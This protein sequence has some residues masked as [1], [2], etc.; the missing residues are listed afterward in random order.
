MRAEYNK[1]FD[2]ITSDLSDDELLYAALRKAEAMETNKKSIKKPVIAACAAAAVVALGV[3]GAAAAGVLRFDEL[4]GKQITASSEELAADLMG[5]AQVLNATCS[6]DDYVVQL[7]GVTGTANSIIANIGAARSDG[8]PLSGDAE[9]GRVAAK[10]EDVDKNLTASYRS[11]V[12]ENGAASFTIE[13]SMSP[14]DF[15]SDE[16]LTGK[17]ILMELTGI[18]LDGAKPFEFSVEYVYTPSEASLGSLSGEDLT[19]SCN[20]LFNISGEGE[21]PTGRDIPFEV[22]LDSI[23]LRAEKGVISGSYDLGGYDFDKYV[24]NTFMCKN[25]IELIMAD[26]STAVAS[27]G[28]YRK[29]LDGGRVNFSMELEYKSIYEEAATAVDLTQVKALSINGTEYKVS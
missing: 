25:D 23:D 16:V 5:Q 24:M 20:I 18:E 8:K 17:T 29:T 1:L 3:T 7:K 15:S 11:G 21:L 4:F 12:I 6:N 13:L 26:G 28:G 9:L 14:E 2:K 10:C 27:L 19:Q 22:Q